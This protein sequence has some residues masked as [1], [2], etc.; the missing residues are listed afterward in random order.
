MNIVQEEVSVSTEHG[1]LNVSV[2]CCG[3][4]TSVIEASAVP[5]VTPILM[6]AEQFIPASAEHS[7]LRVT[8]SEP[9]T[10]GAPC[11]PVGCPVSGRR[12][13]VSSPQVPTCD[14]PGA[15]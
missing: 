11:D 8:Y 10:I 13:S 6:C 2:M 7:P 4:R 9:V 1:P 3:V 12:D 14:G 15:P 5:V